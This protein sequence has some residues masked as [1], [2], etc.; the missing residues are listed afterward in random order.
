MSQSANS[1]LGLSSAKITPN[2]SNTDDTKIY[3]PS[4]PVKGDINNES[5]KNIKFKDRYYIDNSIYRQMRNIEGSLGQNNKYLKRFDYDNAISE[6]YI[7]RLNKSNKKLTMPNDFVYGSTDAYYAIPPHI[8][9]PTILSMLPG[10][11]IAMNQYQYMNRF[12]NATPDSTSTINKTPIKNTTKLIVVKPTE[13][14]NNSIDS[15]QKYQQMMNDIK[16][17]QEQDKFDASLTRIRDK[18]SNEYRNKYMNTPIRAGS[19]VYKPYNP[20]GGKAK[21]PGIF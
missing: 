2:V 7:R 20:I 14:N 9:S 8:K 16:A 3:N 5:V 1:L 10:A 17:Q 12:T 4:I 11:Q 19:D 18:S 21:V 13:N 15:D 6:N